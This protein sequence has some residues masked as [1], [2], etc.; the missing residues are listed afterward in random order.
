MGCSRHVASRENSSEA[1]FGESP[2]GAKSNRLGI[3]LIDDY[4]VNHC[5]TELAKG[6]RRTSGIQGVL[7]HGTFR[8]WALW[9]KRRVKPSRTRE[10]SIRARQKQGSSQ[11]AGNTHQ[12][13]PPN[14]GHCFKQRLRSTCPNVQVC[15]KKRY[16]NVMRGTSARCSTR[17]ADLVARSP[18]S[19]S[20]KSKLY[21][22]IM[23]RTH[24][25]LN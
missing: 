17:N 23:L 4:T 10:H 11:T 20:L 13:N 25:R 9:V 18:G 12:S 2:V 14:K 6:L 3:M 19:D 22:R 15:W 5:Q 24:L 8:G 21:Y 7:L 16:V 1:I